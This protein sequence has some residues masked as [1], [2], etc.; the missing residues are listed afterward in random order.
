[1]CDDFWDDDD[2]QVVCRQLGF[3]GNGIVGSRYASNTHGEMVQLY[4]SGIPWNSEGSSNNDEM[5]APNPAS[6]Q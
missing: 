5:N 4:A 1:M 3:P 6:L 2:A